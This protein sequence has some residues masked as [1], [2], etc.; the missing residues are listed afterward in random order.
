MTRAG[1][2]ASEEPLAVPEPQ[3]CATC[4]TVLKGRQKRYCCGECKRAWTAE[5]WRL[6]VE[7]MEEGP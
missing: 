1:R 5:C 2:K 3:F 6:G 4:G 7:A